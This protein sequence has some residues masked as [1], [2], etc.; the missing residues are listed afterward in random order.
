[1]AKTKAFLSAFLIALMIS[2]LAFVGRIDF[3][4]AQSGLITYINTDTTWATANSPYSFTGPVVVSTGVTLT[5]NAGVTVNLNNYFLYVNGTFKAIGDSTDKI[6]IYGGNITFGN[7]L[8][9]QLNL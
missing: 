1:M 3:G 6:Q 2:G 9:Q 4:L 7:S 8:R 5:I